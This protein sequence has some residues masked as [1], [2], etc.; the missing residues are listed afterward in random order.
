MP[1]GDLT[2]VGERG[3]T[4][5]GGQKQRINLARA[6]Y[7]QREI[8]LLDD[9][10]SSLDSDVAGTIFRHLVRGL[11]REKIIVLVTHLVKV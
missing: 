11:L 5:S 1:E 6:A 10:F 9:P 8:Y 2:V 4:L 7:S 3:V